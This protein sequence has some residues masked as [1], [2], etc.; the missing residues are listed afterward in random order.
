[1]GRRGR[2]AGTRSRCHRGGVA[3]RRHRAAVGGTRRGRLDHAAVDH[4]PR[5]SRRRANRSLRRSTGAC[6]V[7]RQIGTALLGLG[8]T[9]AALYVPA[10]QAH[11]R[12]ELVA[13]SSSHA[14]R[15][16]ETAAARKIAHAY[17][18]WREAVADPSVELVVV[19][20]A[21]DARAQQL[22][23]ALRAGRHILTR[24][25]FGDSRDEAAILLEAARETQ[26][27]A[28]AALPLRYLSAF[29]ALREL[30]R[31]AHLGD[32]RLAAWRQ[33]SAAWHR[34]AAVHAVDALRW[35]LGGASSHIQRLEGE[36]QLLLQMRNGAD[37]AS[38]L[39]LDGRG[40]TEDFSFSVSGSR[41][42]ALVVGDHPEDGELHVI[43]GDRDDEYALRPS[44]Y[45]RFAAA[46]RLVPPL[47]ELLDDL[48]L[49][50][51]G[52]AMT[53]PALADA[54]AAMDATTWA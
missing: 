43:E 9:A 13:L 42:M 22:R 53:A 29:Q 48:A 35:T 28:G 38:Q 37:C 36:R 19:A 45:Q 18:D 7:S 20:S 47:L 32:A 31:G 46:H 44:R 25:P 24:V 27:V 51:D 21:H 11:P 17:D 26:R 12:Y 40:A 50:I 14:G 34:A 33:V 3:P 41:R 4:R 23:E 1:M 30:V 16:A 54:A 2:R 39:A 8:R 10:L 49:A 5:G 52:N 6:C 15:A